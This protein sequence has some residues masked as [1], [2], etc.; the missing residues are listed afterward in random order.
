MIKAFLHHHLDRARAGVAFNALAHCHVPHLD[1]IVLH[2]EHANRI[3]MFF[4]NYGHEL[5]RNEIGQEFSLAIH[6][7]HCD[8]RLV[9]LFGHVANERYGL[10]PHAEGPFAEM[11]YSSGIS[12]AGTMKHTGNRAVAT[13][14][15]SDALSLNKSEYLEAYELHSIYVPAQTNAA[16]LV[17]EGAEDKHYSSTCWTNATEEFNPEGLYQPMPQETI[18]DRLERALRNL[19]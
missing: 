16:W 1:S 6:S 12:G 19:A 13:R 10:T 3:R 2:D 18:I 5:H 8:V 15:R 7:H 14:L 17:F 11:Y 9:G 4:A